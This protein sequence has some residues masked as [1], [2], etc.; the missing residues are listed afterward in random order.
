MKTTYYSHGKLLLSGEYA[1]LDGARALALPTRLGQWLEVH[2]DQGPGL[3]WTSLHADGTP[4]LEA[5]F[6]P[7]ALAQ[8]PAP[9]TFPA[10]PAARLLRILQTLVSMQPAFL[11]KMLGQRVVTR[12]EFPRAWGL[13]SSSTLLANLAEWAGADPY[14]LSDQTLGG[15]GYDLACARA[16]HPIYYRRIPPHPPQVEAAPFDPPFAESLWFVYL[17]VKQDSREGIRR[18]RELKAVPESLLAEISALGERMA[19]ATDLTSFSEAMERHEKLLSELLGLPPVKKRLFVDYAGSLK[20]L[21]AWGGDFIL[22]AGNA[23][24]PRYFLERGYATCL[25]YGELIV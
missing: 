24:T 3:S 21:G 13:G 14:A 1:V 7:E 10:D 11:P 4:W 8:A 18:Y 17:N 12:L 16:D 2:E 22:A 9:S 5:Y 6:E 19:R 25:A 20:S 15:S 23:D